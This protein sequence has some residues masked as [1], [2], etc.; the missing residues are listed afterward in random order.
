MSHPGHLSPSPTATVLPTGQRALRQVFPRGT[1]LTTLGAVTPFGGVVAVAGLG[2]SE[3][4][5]TG[6]GGILIGLL[7]GAVGVSSLVAAWSARRSTMTVD[8]SA[9]WVNNGHAEGVILWQD[10]A[11]VGLYWS[12]HRTGRRGSIRVCS[13][14]LCPNSV[15]RHD[16]SV[17]GRTVRD[18]E[19]LHPG[20]PRPRYRLTLPASSQDAVVTAVQHHVPHLW[21]GE[22]ER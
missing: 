16:D 4:S 15:V 7:M 8:E 19:P 13:L 22:V 3:P 6:F 2:N 5:P 17:I 1:V 9:L 21:F 12:R 10:L 11:G 20:L 14:D 18:E